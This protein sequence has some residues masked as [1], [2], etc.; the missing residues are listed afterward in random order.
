MS[1][2][3]PYLKIFDTK[4]CGCFNNPVELFNPCRT[5]YNYVNRPD[6]WSGDWR[7]K[8]CCYPFWEPIDTVTAG[9][10]VDPLKPSS[11]RV[12]GG[13]IDA[14]RD[15][16]GFFIE[17]ASGSDNLGSNGLLEA[18]AT[19]QVIAADRHAELTYIDWLVNTLE[20][21]GDIGLQV[22][23]F[24][25]SDVWVG[26][27]DDNGLPVV[28]PVDA[29]EPLRGESLCD[30]AG[31][32]LPWSSPPATFWDSGRRDI[33]TARFGGID[34]LSNEVF[35]NGNQYQIFFDIQ[36]SYWY[37][38]EVKVGEV[39]TWDGCKP[40]D[41]D[42]K[43]LAAANTCNVD[44]DDA[45]S[46]WSNVWVSGKNLGIDGIWCRPEQVYVQSFLTTPQPY[47]NELAFSARVIG[48]G[49]DVYNLRVAVH[50]AVDGVAPPDSK[51]G[52]EFYKTEKVLSEFKIGY[53][54]ANET[55][56]IK[57]TRKVVKSC[58]KVEQ[59]VSNS[60]KCGSRYWVSVE[61]S[62]DPESY[63]ARDTIVE[64]F[65]SGKELI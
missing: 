42:T 53:L 24:R 13:M 46:V 63:G 8:D 4:S 12:A 39:N 48:G 60:V 27:V 32:L 64:V 6:T 62:T 55:I 58:G 15:G 1:W 31:L 16:E 57:P 61:M 50:E 65:L 49:A 7:V 18:F 59:I 3:E 51:E 9:P 19:F 54:P 45:G 37:T 52:F 36:D 56:E 17:S 43:T 25:T 47:S 29:E 41:N 21:C 5:Y 30:A 35:C 10:W 40:L 28:V 14:N 33:Y 20:S 22:Y 34:M 23:K 26:P 2:V 38:P 44:G 11:L